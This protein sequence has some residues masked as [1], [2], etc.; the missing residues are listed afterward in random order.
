M[1]NLV[2]PADE[3]SDFRDT[4]VESSLPAYVESKEILTTT[5]PERPVRLRELDGWRAI[6]ALL[7]IVHH[8]GADR[9]PHL[10]SRV[11]GAL[12]LVDYW[13]PL[14]VKI[15]FVISGFVICRLLIS[16]ESTYGSVSLKAFYYRRALRILPPLYTYLAVIYLLVCGGLVR[17]T[18]RPLVCAALFLSDIRHIPMPHSWFIAHTWS[19]AIEEQF[20]LVFPA[21]FLLTSRMKRRTMFLVVFIL[22]AVWNLS[23]VYR[24]WDWITS[25]QTRAGFASISFGVLMA[26]F[27]KP[28]RKLVGSAPAVLAAGTAGILFLIPA[29]SASV[30]ATL[31]QSL[32]VPMAIGLVLLFS[33]DRGGA[34][35][36]FLC[37]WP[38]QAVGATSYGIYLWQQLFTAPKIFVSETGAGSYFTPRGE[39]IPLLLP[40]LLLI[41]PASYRFIEKPAMRLGKRITL[42]VREQQLFAVE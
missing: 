8:V 9:H 22:M 16:E 10:L 15:F 3:V 2:A 21:L 18:G 1:G 36:R 37:S 38:M 42:R 32:I 35:R 27:E 39:V 7:V 17:D 20:Y 5:M 40:L 24:N 23:N 11:P 13:G 34:L 19:L 25:A 41:V 6:S 28:L 12:A 30:G 33:L 14:A 4:T 31:Y 29:G 26:V